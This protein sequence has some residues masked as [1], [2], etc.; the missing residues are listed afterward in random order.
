MPTRDT[1]KHAMLTPFRYP[2]INGN[3]ILIEIFEF[4]QNSEGLPLAFLIPMSFNES[5]VDLTCKLFQGNR[6]STICIWASPRSLC[7]AI[8]QT[9]P[10]TPCSIPP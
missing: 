1:I 2:Y 3:L 6:L 9:L 4:I 5:R 10:F 8:N 7:N